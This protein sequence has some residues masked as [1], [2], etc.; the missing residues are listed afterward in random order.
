MLYMYFVLICTIFILRKKMKNIFLCA[1]SLLSVVM[2]HPAV[3]AFQ[4]DSANRSEDGN[5][6]QINFDDVLKR[7]GL[8]RPLNYR[9]GHKPVFG[10]ESHMAQASVFYVAE[11]GQV[12]NTVVLNDV[13]IDSQ[14]QFDHRDDLSLVRSKQLSE[15]LGSPSSLTLQRQRHNF[16]YCFS[17]IGASILDG[18]CKGRTLARKERVFFTY[19]EGISLKSHCNCKKNSPRDLMVLCECH[20]FTKTILE[21]IKV[22]SD[23]SKNWG[24]LRHVIFQHIKETESVDELNGFLSSSAPL[25][26]KQSLINL[27]YRLGRK[28]SSLRNRAY[29]WLSGHRN[30]EGNLVV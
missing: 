2:Q 1:I 3:Y 7:Y 24:T 4:D 21:N 17:C 28:N 20:C 19:I 23:F 10:F 8:S 14:K 25:K 11:E 18:T 29:E 26:E 30:N 6:S 5:I 16:N 27:V 22:S 15:K 9:D 12:S 13:N